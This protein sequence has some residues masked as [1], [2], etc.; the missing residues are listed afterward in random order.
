MSLLG[1]SGKFDHKTLYFR[2]KSLMY[3]Y[4]NHTWSLFDMVFKFFIFGLKVRKSSKKKTAE[5]NFLI[6]SHNII[7]R[8][9]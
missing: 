6:F 3:A 5:M 9:L 2:G 8:N 4:M 7:K 1:L